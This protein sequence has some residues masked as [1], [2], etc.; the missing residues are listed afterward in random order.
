[1]LPLR[2]ETLRARAELDERDELSLARAESPEQRLELVLEL[3]DLIQEL[4]EQA[5]PGDLV[6]AV[7][8]EDKARLYVAPLRGAAQLRRSLPR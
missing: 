2:R 3:S 4:S 5:L 1:M 8:L 7:P 6:S